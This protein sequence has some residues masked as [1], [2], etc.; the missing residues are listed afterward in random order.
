MVQDASRSKP[1]GTER[2]L[3]E[4]FN[5]TVEDFKN[6][7][8]KAI[9]HRIRNMYERTGT[10]IEKKIFKYVARYVMGRV[11]PPTSIEGLPVDEYP[12]WKS[13]SPGWIK[14]KHSNKK[15]TWTGDLL[16]YLKAKDDAQY[17]Y[18][19]PQAKIDY[20][21]KTV[22]YYSMFRDGRKPFRAM[23][24]EK[25]RKTKVLEEEKIQ[26]AKADEIK[27]DGDNPYRP[28]IYPM[29]EFLLYKK[30]DKVMDER[31]KQFMEEEY[32]NEQ[33]I[34]AASKF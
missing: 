2:D 3:L 31:L 11:N 13:L 33:L 7:E 17:W 34:P 18:K 16:K 26:M 5:N 10:E 19:K 15:F 4:W 32:E 30:L 14:K 6:W 28:L 21:N 24:S 29:E 12:E 20:K 1:R 9:L 8:E 27:H 23:S 22:T 25:K